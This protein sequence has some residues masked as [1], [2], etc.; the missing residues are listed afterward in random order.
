MKSK[1]HVFL[2]MSFVVTL[3]G[4]LLSCLLSCNEKSENDKICYHPTCEFELTQ[5]STG[6]KNEFQELI[7][8]RGWHRVNQASFKITYRLNTE[9]TGLMEIPTHTTSWLISQFTERTGHAVP[10]AVRLPT[11]YVCK[12]E[13][14][15]SNEAVKPEIL[16]LKH[17]DSIVIKAN[18]KSSYITTKYEVGYRHDFY[19]PT[20]DE[21]ALKKVQEYESKFEKNTI[22]LLNQ[23]P[24]CKKD[25]TKNSNLEQREKRTE[26]DQPEDNLCTDL[27]KTQKNSQENS[28]DHRNG[29]KL[30]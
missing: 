18:P 30:D 13:I 24:Y 19:S 21:A 16:F 4:S 29:P 9:K 17:E 2:F 22:A 10:D 11:Q 26:Q 27:N 7:E 8:K 3:L 15:A 23:L 6:W 1:I 25:N 5:D 14:K 12:L 28:K 20:E